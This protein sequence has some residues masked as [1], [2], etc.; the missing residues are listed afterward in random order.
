MT[1]AAGQ[2]TKAL[3]LAL[4]A[5]TQFVIVLDASIVNCVCARSASASAL[6]RWPAAAVM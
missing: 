5:L 6:V 3:A 2:R 1:A 4:L